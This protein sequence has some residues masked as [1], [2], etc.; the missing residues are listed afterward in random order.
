MRP[1]QVEMF[2][3]INWSLWES[4]ALGVELLHPEVHMRKLSM[5]TYEHQTYHSPNVDMPLEID[6]SLLY[7]LISVDAAA[8]VI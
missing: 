5:E 8:M 1:D 2:E 6:S 4:V 3:L 7:N